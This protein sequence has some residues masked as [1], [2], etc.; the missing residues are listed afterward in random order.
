MC[1]SSFG[2]YILA[3]T[4]RVTSTAIGL[5]YSL[6]STGGNNY[7]FER[8]RVFLCGGIQTHVALMRGVSVISGVRANVIPVNATF[9]C[10][11]LQLNIEVH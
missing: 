4:L 3:L 2:A 11:P 7:R 6:R 1:L 8:C 5:T 10:V 9:S